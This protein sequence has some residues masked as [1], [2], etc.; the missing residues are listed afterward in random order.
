MKSNFSLTELSQ[1]SSDRD[2]TCSVRKERSDRGPCS[3]TGG[4]GCFAS[5]KT[6]TKNNIVNVKTISLEK[7]DQLIKDEIKHLG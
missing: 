2:R 1:N 4:R 5:F 6:N 3:V 7:K